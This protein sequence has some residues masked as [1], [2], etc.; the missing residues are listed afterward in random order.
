MA[1]ISGELAAIM[2]A[3][4][5]EEVRQSIHDAISKINTYAEDVENRSTVS[6]YNYKGSVSDGSQLPVN[7]NKPGDC[8]YVLA[9]G[10]TYAWS[11]AHWHSI[12]SHVTLS[13][14]LIEITTADIDTM[15][16]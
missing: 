4:Y 1:D 13:I 15:F 7:S 8:S 12:G 6:A 11:G 10:E 14:D 5:G 3:T 16:A 9:N 2:S